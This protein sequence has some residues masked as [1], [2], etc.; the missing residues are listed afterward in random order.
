MIVLNFILKVLILF[1]FERGV[2][3][4]SSYTPLSKKCEKISCSRYRPADHRC[5]R[6]YAFDPINN[7]CIIKC[8]QSCY[9]DFCTFCT[10]YAFGN[11]H[12]KYNLDTSGKICERISKAVHCDKNTCG[13]TPVE[14]CNNDLYVINP[15]DA[16]ECIPRC[17]AESCRNGWCSEGYCVCKTGYR[18]N[19][20]NPMTCM[21]IPNYKMITYNN[22]THE[23]SNPKINKETSVATNCSHKGNDT[24]SDNSTTFYEYIDGHDMNKMI[25]TRSELQ[26][27]ASDNEMIDADS[28]VPN[29]FTLYIAIFVSVLTILLIAVVILVF[30]VIKMKKQESVVREEAETDSSNNYYYVVMSQQQQ[31]AMFVENP[32]IYDEIQ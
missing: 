11:Y 3:E 30:I 18:P 15:F 1:I 6:A 31:S 28:M 27:D 16:Y 20:I 19:P 12:F 22:G 10:C 7:E 9:K 25:N 4:C 8:E 17:T 23:M 21:E 32:E 13:W 26:P 29:T 5:P 24:S 14:S 2:S